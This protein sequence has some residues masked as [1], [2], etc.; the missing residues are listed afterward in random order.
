MDSSKVAE[1]PHMAL[2]VWLCFLIQA[3]YYTI[4]ASCTMDFVPESI[5]DA[6]QFHKHKTAEVKLAASTNDVAI[7]AVAAHC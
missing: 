2:G 5:K 1:A 4:Q 6:I 3:A 7:V